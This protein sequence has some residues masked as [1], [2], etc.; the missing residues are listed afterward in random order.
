M[1]IKQLA[2]T[3][4]A[5]L[6][7][8]GLAGADDTNT[9]TPSAPAVTAAAA[10]APAP[11]AVAPTNSPALAAAK[12]VAS[13]ATA[14]SAAEVSIMG[15]AEDITPTNQVKMNF[16]DAPLNIIMKYLSAR[17]G[18]VIAADI[19][20]HGT[21]TI[22]SEQPVNKDEV[23]TLLAG[24][25]AK[26]GYSVVR[27]G[28]LIA[29]TSME[30]ATTG[31]QTPVVEATN[32][33]DSIPET[34]EMAT[35]IIPMQTL[36]PVQLIKDLDQ[37]IPPGAKVAANEA[38]NAV[39]MTAR[40]K[41]I[42]RFAEII[43]ALD[44]SSVSAVEVF[45]LKNADAKSVADELKEVFQSPDSS[46]ARDAARSQRFR[47]FGGFGGAFGGG[48]GGDNS[49]S[50]QKNAS[51]KAVFT[52]DDLMNA[53]IAAAPPSYFPMITN[54][55]HQLDQPSDEIT[56]V[57]T[58]HLKFSDAQSIADEITTLF[59]PDSTKNND[60][61]QR[62][63]GFRF[64]PPWMQQQPQNSGQSDRMK[65]QLTVTAVPDLRTH[66]VI[67]TASRDEMKVVAKLIEEVD[68]DPA[69]VQHVYAIPFDYGDPVSMQ[70]ALQALFA[71]MNSTHPQNN[72]N[73]TSP[74]E[75]RAQTAAQ[76]Q[77]TQTSGFGTT[78]GG[79]TP[80]VP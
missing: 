47:G 71:S 28:R 4:L 54:V 65:R 9:T 25:L 75:T 50:D 70:T 32:G 3:A 33:P 39:I 48:G 17:M 61:T 41:D 20:I 22:I 67:V 44:G 69:Q 73:N 72:N 30:S 46:V 60:Q 21:A 16:H 56:E 5:A 55:I 7:I 27:N 49:N 10:A 19:P 51:N 35:V 14:P 6:A 40:Q 1:K 79:G 59:N 36:P 13:A 76:Q 45:V 24:A 12:A 68:N 63:L 8:Q 74:L 53:V 29:I 15:A 11:A 77:T 26:N 37:L 18:F 31:A 58:F 34:E 42:H 64:T 78:G 57:Q 80:A 38:G 62:S 52:S 23:Y 2:C 66:S 43:K